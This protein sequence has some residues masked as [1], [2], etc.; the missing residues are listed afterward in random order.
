[1]VAHHRY[2]FQ[3]R[4]GV[5]KAG[6]AVDERVVVDLGQVEA[7]LVGIHALVDPVGV[8][9]YLDVHDCGVEPH[10]IHASLVVEDNRVLCVAV[11]V[12]GQ[13]VHVQG[14]VAAV[15]DEEADPAC[16]EGL[17]GRVEKLFRVVTDTH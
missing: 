12:A 14:H 8:L 4:V 5:G 2:R 17:A 15:M 7:V 16:R 3:F 10:R 13:A 1:M 11:D 6:H 9:L